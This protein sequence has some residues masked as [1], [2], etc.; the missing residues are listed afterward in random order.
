MIKN[1]FLI[2]VLSLYFCF[3]GLIVASENQPMSAIDWLG[4]KINDPP[5][6]YTFP[7]EKN[8]LDEESNIE[9]QVNQLPGVSK[10]SIGIFGGIRLGLP[11]DIWS[12]EIETSIANEIETI[13]PSNLFRLNRFLKKVSE[14]ILGFKANKDP[15]CIA[16]WWGSFSSRYWS[17]V[18]DKLE[19][20][21]F[22][23]TEG[24]GR[25]IWVMAC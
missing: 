15:T 20:N 13:P 7:R 2:A 16:S 11:I 19:N 22:T 18:L 8:G 21:S 24:H 10:N 5:D 6:F 23:N 17:Y 14:G 1:G 9:I 3:S 25:T 12:G 4:E